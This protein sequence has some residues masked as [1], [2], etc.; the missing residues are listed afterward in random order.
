MQKNSSQGELGFNI[1]D[2]N[3]LSNRSVFTIDF[4]SEDL[5]G[6]HDA[7]YEEISLLQSYSVRRTDC[8]DF[9]DEKRQF[10][11]LCAPKGTG[12]TT[13]CRLW[14]LDIDKKKNTISD[15]KF[16]TEVSPD[17]KDASLTQWIR[18]WKHQITKVIISG[19]D[20]KILPVVDIEQVVEISE[21]KQNRRKR[22]FELLI[23][24]FNSVLGKNT[25]AL[26]YEE[27]TNMLARLKEMSA[28][29]IWIFL[30]EI[31]QYF[32][33]EEYSIRK[34]GGM[35]LAA[36]ELTGHLSNLYLRTTIKPNVLAILLS[37]IDNISNIRE[38]IV[39]LSWND[40]GIRAIL[41]KR[42]ESYLERRGLYSKA[43][44]LFPIKEVALREEWLVSQVFSTSNFDLGKNNRPPHK[45]LSV[46]SFRRPRWLLD[47]CKTVTSGVKDNSVRTIS[48][49]YVEGRLPDYGKDRMVDLTTEYGTQCPQLNLIIQGF[50]NRKS[51][52]Y[53]QELEDMVQA[54]IASK[55]NVEIVGVS[56]QCSGRQ[57]IQF[58]FE[59]GFIEPVKYFKDKSYDVIHFDKSP[60]FIDEEGTIDANQPD[61]DLFWKIHPAFRNALFLTKPS[62]NNRK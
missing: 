7:A 17:L 50:R 57:I 34:V 15:V 55:I 43:S 46:L 51:S 16:D 4:T 9:F 54:N 28:Y 33:K 2:N 3:T 22:L 13:I 39:N 26:T 62:K 48:F 40:E 49:D 41:A 45:I 47:L 61:Y 52:Y 58:L 6:H 30:D 42:V 35:L 25:K 23:E 12:K 53:Y 18:A 37:K 38:L 24:N 11:I 60:N 29:N 10:M 44:D 31:D 21:R 5:F 19:I 20:E 32:T 56:V 59:I 36:R 27:Q 8:Q 14:Q 1:D